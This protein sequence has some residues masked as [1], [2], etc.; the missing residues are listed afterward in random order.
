MTSKI[1][2][3]TLHPLYVSEDVFNTPLEGLKKKNYLPFFDNWIDFDDIQHKYFLRKERQEPPEQSKRT[4]YG[5][6]A[7]QHQASFSRVHISSTGFIHSFF[8]HFDADDAIKKMRKGRNWNRQNKY[9]GLT[10]DE[11]K[12][13]WEKNRVE[14]STAG[15][16]MHELIEWFYEFE[17]KYVS[18]AHL[19]YM[20]DAFDMPELLQFLNFHRTEVLPRGW[21][22]FR[23]ELRA[24][25]R[26]HNL[27]GSV[28][29]IFI[30]PEGKLVVVDWKRSKEIK[31]QNRYQ[32]G[33]GPLQHLD[34]CNFFHY[35][36]QLNLYDWMLCSQL[37]Y[38][39]EALYLGVFH[40]NQRDYQM[41]QVPSMQREI[42]SMLAVRLQ[43]EQQEGLQ[44]ITN[45]TSAL[46]EVQRDHLHIVKSPALL[47][48]VISLSK[49]L[50]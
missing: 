14:A 4:A 37:D 44:L 15:T 45:A 31:T 1:D 9:Y 29:M 35:S 48:E 26:K 43:E 19:E 17:G 34:D 13:M 27:A 38:Q 50:S 24:F 32:K 39:V 18:E 22:P 3:R 36:L 2:L 47:A 16:R 12:A 46:E 25:S 21:K 20:A 5:E 33:L 30:T 28:D 10:D 6:K 42:Q 8:G 7:K 11:I 41:I 49:M 23:T 40:P